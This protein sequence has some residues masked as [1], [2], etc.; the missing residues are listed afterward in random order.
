MSGLPISFFDRP[1]L[2]LGNLL[3]GDLRGAGTALVAPEKL[4]PSKLQRRLFGNLKDMAK[5]NPL[6][7]G[8]MSVATDPL[9]IIS[10]IMS[11]KFPIANA[12]D[13]FTYGK[14][15][16]GYAHKPGFLEGLFGRAERIF[17]NTNIPKLMVRNVEESD[18]FTRLWHTRIA[19]AFEDFKKSTGHYPTHRE[20]LLLGAKLD[21]LDKAGSVAGVS[22]PLLA[23][24][25]QLSSGLQSLHDK[26]KGF[27]ADFN[28]DVVVPLQQSEAGVKRLGKTAV[29]E[30]VAAFGK[31]L[32]EAGVRGNKRNELMAAFK[33]KVGKVAPGAEAAA[34]GRVLKK[35]GV[36]E[37]GGRDGF[38]PHSLIRSPEMQRDFALQLAEDAKGDVAAFRRASEASAVSQ[39]SGHAL[40]RQGALAPALAELE[41]VGKLN[42]KAISQLVARQKT[43]A[44][45]IW[46]DVSQTVDRMVDQRAT[47]QFFSAD[48][49]MSQVLKAAQKRGVILP[50]GHPM[51]RKGYNAFV[52]GDF[53]T[54]R[55]SMLDA[56]VKGARK[57]REY[58]LFTG[59]IV[60]NYVHSFTRPYVWLVQEIGKGF[61]ALDPKMKFGK[62]V[63]RETGR[64]SSEG[65]R[66]MK[67]DYLPLMQGQVT[68]QQTVGMVRWAN[69]R[70]KMLD[71]LRDGK[72][73]AKV[74]P[75]KWRTKLTD[76][77]TADRGPFG[78]INANNKLAGYFYYSTLSFNP[79]SAFQ[80]MMQ[81]IIT[82]AP[83]VGMQP[84]FKGLG[85]TVQKLT[86]PKG[87]FT[88]RGKG[89][90]KEVAMG[91]VFP[92]YVKA[93]LSH[94]SLS[95][96]ILSETLEQAFQGASRMPAAGIIPGKGGNLSRIKRMAMMLFSG[97]ERFNRLVTFESGMAKAVKDGLAGGKAR[98]FAATVVRATQFPAG[99]GQMPRVLLKLP[100]PWRQFMYFPIRYA[101]FLAESTLLGGKGK[102]DFGTMFRTLGAS[103]AAYRIA[104]EGL[105]LDMS[106]SLALGAL[107]LPEYE[108]SPFFPFP[109][110]PPIASIG[111]NLIK[112]AATGDARPLE[113]IAALAIPGGV[114]LTRTIKTLHP[115]FAK[116]D[117]PTPD[118][119]IPVFSQSGSLVGHHTKGQL[120][121]RALGLK[122]ADQVTEQNLMGYLTKHRDELREARRQY[123][124]AT[125][126]G[127]IEEAQRIQDVF[128]RTYPELGKI[129]VKKSDLEAARKRREMSRLQ[130]MLKTLP[131]QFQPAF[132][133]VVSAAMAN[134]T[135]NMFQGAQPVPSMF[136][137]G[138]GVGST[139]PAFGFGS[140]P[141]FDLASGPDFGL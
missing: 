128:A 107:P 141:S 112:A 40:P 81:P 11:A 79:A 134:D 42:P 64:L 58:S 106:K 25:I 140:T 23:K 28:K 115:K 59:N 50:S 22:A 51:V 7:A 39:M 94:S 108:N 60:R 100:A 138:R 126:N 105:G 13:M 46:A 68:E 96:S 118:G 124:D 34:R 62:A 101:G 19:G 86:G 37:M 104:K 26:L 4:A 41:K 15:F 35:A 36:S 129:D 114:Q 17:A 55:S 45:N 136:G 78:Y 121:M 80:N 48:D 122:P 132:A 75:K 87:Y 102:R 52:Q 91:R 97:S 47:D 61:E 71:K 65:K 53:E 33:A 14:K 66:M 38:F 99:P 8:I 74:L 90:A 110:V 111:G 69:T 76:M 3:A 83:M 44:S 84:F 109:V 92:E 123:I 29:A 116:Y 30:K 139:S 63:L 1:D 12:K 72:G 2:A 73:L 43:Q 135:V 5:D 16:A 82:T 32:S 18:K 20:H 77:L 27:F 127:D 130:R 10:L 56:V 120:M 131:K 98:D 133:D 21:G 57:H 70:L 95:Q 137:G 113:R 93:G 54:F 67:S 31:S 119:R 89:V 125:M 117:Q 88:L 6:L 49:A 85:S 24:K 9:V 103:A